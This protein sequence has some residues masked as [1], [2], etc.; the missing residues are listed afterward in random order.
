MLRLASSQGTTV[1]SGAAYLTTWRSSRGA[2]S[3]TMR[4]TTRP[5]KS[6]KRCH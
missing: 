6:Q 5:P 2:A 4:H 3:S 1:L